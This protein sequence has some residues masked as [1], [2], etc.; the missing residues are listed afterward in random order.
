MHASDPP[1]ERWNEDSRKLS[2]EAAL[3]YGRHK[4]GKKDEEGLAA[5][6]VDDVTSG[7]YYTLL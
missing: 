2:L 3:L 6:T 5:L 4:S 7:Y 1:N